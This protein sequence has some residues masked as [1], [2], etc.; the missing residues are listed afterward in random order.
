MFLAFAQLVVMLGEFVFTPKGWL[1]S[2]LGEK[3]NQ[4]LISECKGFA[5]AR[6]LSRHKLLF[7]AGCAYTVA[8]LKHKHKYFAGGAL[9]CATSGF[10]RAACMC[11]LRSSNHCT[12][13]ACLPSSYFQN[14]KFGDFGDRVWATYKSQPVCK[15]LLRMYFCFRLSSKFI[16]QHLKF[17]F[18]NTMHP[19]DDCSNLF[20]LCSSVLSCQ[21]QS[22]FG[23][24]FDLPLWRELKVFLE[25][26][27]LSLAQA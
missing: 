25:V 15:V 2:L 1:T 21:E 4:G 14:I 7:F 27:E 9:L 19:L 24:D 16:E 8:S 12:S 5:L 18:E 22:L 23:S 26:L 20:P 17:W 3:E 10:R 13:R 6:V 11:C